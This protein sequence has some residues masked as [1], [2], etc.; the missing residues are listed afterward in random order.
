METAAKTDMDLAVTVVATRLPATPT[1][2]LAHFSAGVGKLLDW[3]PTVG[4]KISVLVT[5]S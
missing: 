4:S 5:L 1:G 2:G 3:W